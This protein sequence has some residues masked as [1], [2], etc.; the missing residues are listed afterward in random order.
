MP[1]ILE[2]ALRK[3][4]NSD[5]V[6]QMKARFFF[7]L[8]LI[9]LVI[10]PVTISYTTYLH[11]QNPVLGYRIDFAI[12]MPQIITLGLFIAILVL[13]VRGYFTA[14][15][16]VIL[17]LLLMTAWTVMIE[18]RSFVVS[19]L[20]TIAFIFGILTL[21]PLAVARNGTAIIVYGGINLAMLYLFMFFSGSSSTSPAIR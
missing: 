3:Y 19:R 20:D 13:L 9:I 7:F 6:I 1:H 11:L 17:V 10:L 21:T 18:D 15:A 4:E 2:R 8:C 16:H 5:I 12:L 14:S